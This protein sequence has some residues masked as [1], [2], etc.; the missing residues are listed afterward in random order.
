MHIETTSSKADFQGEYSG[1]KNRLRAVPIHVMSGP[2]TSERVNQT[3]VMAD[4]PARARGGVG[5]QLPAHPNLLREGQF[6]FGRQ[7]KLTS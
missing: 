7:L 4:G 3:A 1:T 5:N 2:D 6:A